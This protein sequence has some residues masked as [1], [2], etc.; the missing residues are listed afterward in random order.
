MAPVLEAGIAIGAIVL[1]VI[2]VNRSKLGLTDLARVLGGIH[3]TLIVVDGVPKVIRNALVVK[4]R[5][6]PS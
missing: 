2:G 4:G 5:L 1:G 3:L 6:P